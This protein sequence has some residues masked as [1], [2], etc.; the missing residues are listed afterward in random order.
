MFIKIN[1]FI[2][3]NGMA[4]YKTLDTNSIIMGSQIYPFNENVAYVEYN[5]PFVPHDDLMEVRK[6]EIDS[7]QKSLKI[8]QGPT[9]E[10]RLAAQEQRIRDQE[11]AIM[12]LT[13]I[14]AGGATNV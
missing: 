9:I 11:Q 13:A 7:V 4:D 1:N 14:I 5:E 10:E 6:E 12:E 8:D 2:Q 3:E